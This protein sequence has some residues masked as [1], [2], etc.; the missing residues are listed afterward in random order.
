MLFCA[1]VL[2]GVVYWAQGD[3]ELDR[4][5]LRLSP[6]CI[7][8]GSALLGLYFVVKALSYGLDRFLLLYG[9]NDVVVGAGYTDLH[10]RLPVLWFLIAVAGLSAIAS[11][12]NIIRWRNWQVPVVA[13]VGLFG[14]SLVVGVVFPALFQP[15]YVKPREL[16]LETP[17]IS[18]NIALT[19]EAYS[20][21]RI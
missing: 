6:T 20:L 21:S 16:Q 3:I 5:L 2:A 8:H 4:Q 7:A 9:D 13:V 19:Q 15:F 11:W 10:V 12:A 18:R 14:S 17:Y 1:A